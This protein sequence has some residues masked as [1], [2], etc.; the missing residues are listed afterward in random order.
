M[1][2]PDSPAILGLLALAA[3]LSIGALVLIGMERTV[4]P[5]VWALIAGAVGAVGGWVGKTITTEA[6]EVPAPAEPEAVSAPA[7][8]VPFI[9]SLADPFPLAVDDDE[10]ARRQNNDVA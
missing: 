10:L 9:P 3:I 7:P 5:E 1:K 6:P 4:P 2:R 8:V